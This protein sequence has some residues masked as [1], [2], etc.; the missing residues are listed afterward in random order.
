MKPVN[1]RQLFGLV[2][3][4]ALAAVVRSKPTKPYLP[5][6]T[7]KKAFASFK[8]TYP[9]LTPSYIYVKP[10]D[11]RLIE[12]IPGFDHDVPDPLR[13]I[14]ARGTLWAAIV[15]ERKRCCSDGQFVLSTSTPLTACVFHW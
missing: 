11:L 14:G 8:E 4:V 9:T 3:A 13:R 10:G 6:E 1:R 2:P 12:K 7:L 5:S 15:V